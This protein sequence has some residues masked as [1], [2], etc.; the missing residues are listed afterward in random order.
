MYVIAIAK[1]KSKLI[2]SQVSWICGFLV[3]AVWL[4]GGHVDFKTPRSVVLDPRNHKS[5]GICTTGRAFLPAWK[6]SWCSSDY[7][8]CSF[9][10]GSQVGLPHKHGKLV[11]WHYLWMATIVN[12]LPARKDGPGP[13]FFTTCKRHD[14]KSAYGAVAVGMPVACGE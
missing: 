8:V 13:L 5:C 6:R 2:A 4:N 1:S 12:S 7:I 14:L 9:C 11:A 10:W 3:G